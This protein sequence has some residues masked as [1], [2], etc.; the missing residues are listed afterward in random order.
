MP[1]C[2][3]SKWSLSIKRISFIYRSSFNIFFACVLFFVNKI[4]LS[5]LFCFAISCIDDKKIHKSPIPGL[6]WIIKILDT[7]FFSFSLNLP[8]SLI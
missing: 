2:F 4:I 7:Y 1:E 6:V 8:R 3:E 5:S